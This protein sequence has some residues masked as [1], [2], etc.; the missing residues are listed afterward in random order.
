[1]PNQPSIAIPLDLPDVTVLR[2]EL[3]PRRELILG[4]ER[5]VPSATC[6]QCG[7]TI[8]TFSESVAE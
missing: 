5:T 1:M 2:T 3:T 6:H 7:R 8:E 4:V